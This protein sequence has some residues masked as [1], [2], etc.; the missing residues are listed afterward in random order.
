MAPAEWRSYLTEFSDAFFRKARGSGLWGL[1]DEQ[2]A[3]RWLG[4]GPVSERLLAEAEERLGVR[5]PP[6]L[7]GFLLTTDGWS[8]PADWVDRVCPCHDIQ[9]FAE[10][11]VGTSVIGE[12]SRELRDAPSGQHFLELLKRMLLVADGE[13]VWLLDTGEADADG[14]YAAC[15]LTVRF[16]EFHGR[17]PSF[18][19]LFANGRAEVEESAG[20]AD[21]RE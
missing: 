20:G 15:H 13:D 4:Y 18:S 1:D 2:I 19:A 10:T 3:A 9:W 5:L 21:A 16:G 11:L 12:A 8:R 7:Q 6:S 17:Y 14:E